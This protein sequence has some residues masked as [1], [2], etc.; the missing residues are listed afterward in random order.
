MS[1]I[2][3]DRVASPNVAAATLSSNDGATAPENALALTT[4]PAE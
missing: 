1:P 2:S 3:I 4:A